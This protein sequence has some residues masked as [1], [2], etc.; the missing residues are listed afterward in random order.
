MLNKAVLMGRLCADPA[1][2]TTPSGVSVCAFTL[3]V[4]RNFAK[5]GRRETDFIDCVAWRGTAE[6][7]TQYFSKGKLLALVGRIQARKWED[8]DGNKRVSVEVVAEEASF[9]GERKEGGQARPEARPVAVD[10]PAEA[11]FEQMTGGDLS[12]LPF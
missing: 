12:D 11:G 9:C 2:K 8:K 10:G 6:F 3:A 5:D 1:L 7:V 4:E